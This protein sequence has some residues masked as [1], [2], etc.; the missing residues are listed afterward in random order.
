MVAA[1][2]L[3]AFVAWE[4]RAKNP[5]VALRALGHRSIAAGSAIGLALGF[6]LLGSVF[7]LPQ[8]VN[9]LLNYTATL[10]GLLILVRA[11]PIALLTPLVGVLA[12][13]VDARLLLGVGV[14]IVSGGT[15]WQALIMTSDTPFAT[16]VAPLV[17]Q[18]IG[19]AF[20]AVPL[21]VNVLGSVG[22]ELT[23]T[24]SSFLNL[25]FQLGGSIASAVLVTILDRRLAFHL[26]TL[27]GTTG[28]PQIVGILQAAGRHRRE[29][30]VGLSQLIQQQAAAMTL[31]RPTEPSA[32]T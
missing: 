2:G 13:R 11:A 26:S 9:V 14:L 7:M 22:T 16:L 4:L 8:Y 17:L 21:L 1:V 5:I 23:A 20:L 28:R 29:L 15:I 30:L 32:T 10:S 19:T 24:A 18:G 6:P 27:A 25:S 31:A 12:Q 3:I